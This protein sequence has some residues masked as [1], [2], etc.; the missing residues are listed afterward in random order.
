[1]LSPFTIDPTSQAAAS[2]GEPTRGPGVPE[3]SERV[4]AQAPT[5]HPSFQSQTPQAAPQQWIGMGSQGSPGPVVHPGFGTPVGPGRPVSP[6]QVEGQ[7][8]TPAAR[9]FPQ[10][11][12]PSGVQANLPRATLQGPGMVPPQLAVTQT[13]GLVSSPGQ[14]AGQLQAPATVAGR[15]QSPVTGSAPGQAIRTPPMTV[16]DAG[17]DF[18]LAFELPGVTEEDIEIFGGEQELLLEA[19]VENEPDE[20]ALL[21][22]ESPE[23]LYKRQVP[24]EVPVD[25]ENVA[26]TF[27]NGILE[28]TLP[29]KEP[30]RGLQ[31]IEID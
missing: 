7:A 1:M 29:K 24:L 12:V 5:V 27:E 26:A 17:E 19:S 14:P 25:L 18:V 15:F 31:N 21:S 3:A 23:K 10:Q 16:V 28:V 11:G 20:G 9:Q 13:P 8:G 2:V 4:E 22:S 6:G 30:K